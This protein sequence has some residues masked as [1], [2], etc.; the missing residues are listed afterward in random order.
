MKIILGGKETEIPDVISII[1]LLELKKI[2]PTHTVVEINGE[3][4]LSEHWTETEIAEGDRVE[5]L[6]FV[7]GG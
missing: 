5:I 1:R 7:G 4:I 6:S 3:I 2:S